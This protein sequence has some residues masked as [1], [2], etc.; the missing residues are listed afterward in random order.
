MPNA[1]NQRVFDIPLCE[2]FVISDAQNDLFELFPKD[3]I[4]AASSPEEY[5]E[6]A[7]FYLENSSAKEMI[8]RN[9]KEHILKKHLYRHRMEELISIFRV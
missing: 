5:A 7:K 4:C 8:I 6:L 2:R 3:A 9:A 1:V